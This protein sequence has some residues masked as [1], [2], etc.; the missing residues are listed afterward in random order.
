MTLPLH[1]IAELIV[2]RSL[3]SLV[4]GTIVCL[5]AAV[6]LRITR[7]QSAATRF[8]IWFSALI[9][10]AVLPWLSGSHSGLAASTT[11]HAAI[12]LPDSW[13]IYFLAFW[14]AVVLWYSS[15][16]IRALWYLHVLRR[17]CIAVDSSQ[18]DPMVRETLKRGTGRRAVA[19]YTSDRVRVPTAVGLLNA[20]ILIPSWV[21]DELSPAELKQVLLH[22]LAHLRR[23]DDWTNLAQQVVKALFFFHPAVWWLDKQVAVER[24][25]ACD[26][27]VLDETSSPRA[28]A[29]CLA[30]LAERSLV[31]RGVALAQAALG[32]IWQT[33]IRVARILDG[34]RPA[35][36][37][38]PWR[39]AVSL[40]AIFAVG[41]AVSYSR[42][43]KLI[44]FASPAEGYRAQVAAAPLVPAVHYPL[45]PITPAKF[46]PKSFPRRMKTNR[47]SK[48]I[49]VPPIEPK[50]AG[51]L[52]HL[53]GTKFRTAPLTET[54][55]VVVESNDSNRSSTANYQIQ[56][57]RV[58]IVETV[59]HTS[60]R[61]VPPKQT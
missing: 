35:T 46:V 2:L 30:R 53:A 40:I 43:P 20:A 38:R 8:S 24:E 57:W 61:P 7:R 49:L 39:P 59:T 60:V 47:S 29:E 32:K 36:N 48:R 37:A 16:I 12:T 58:T 18:L 21:M 34:N 11:T 44:R 17:D 6:V 3:D 9:A 14:A 54:F 23:W 28:Y 31:N 51:P 5:C 56:M 10:L 22:E 50:M 45:V 19:L 1:S 55:W 33:S 4:E 42:T 15:G 13:A 52:V 26:D 27:A 25:I 41:C